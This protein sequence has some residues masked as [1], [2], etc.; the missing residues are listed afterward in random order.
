VSDDYLR[1]RQI[2][3]VAPELGPAVA[4]MRA[5]LGLEVCHRDPNV[6]P[7]G[8]E[9]ALFVAGTTFLEIIAPFKE[10]TAAGRFLDRTGGRGGY[11]AL[12]DCPDPKARQTHAEAMGVAA[13][14][15]IDHPGT[16]HGVQLHPRDCRAAMLEF[17]HT[18]GGEAPDGPYWPAG[19]DGWQRH[20]DTSR[21]REVAGI[22]A[23]SADPAGLANHW[24]AIL[25][26]PVANGRIDVD[27]GFVA[28][29]ASDDGRE[30]LD[31]I[32]LDAAD[33]DAMLAEA[34][35]RGR[36]TG[37]DSFLLSGM[38]FRIAESAA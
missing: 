25:Q 2:C 34:E 37:D 33:P 35:R 3:L 11:I 24:S 16:Y 13:A 26:R 5:I 9:N 1:L 29:E 14:Y 27:N 31:A 6:A 36:R 12:F 8:V 4:D 7:F 28:F 20:A 23:T 38:S 15:V 22:V 18:V 19:G 32:L 30:R 10:G 21:T 17:D